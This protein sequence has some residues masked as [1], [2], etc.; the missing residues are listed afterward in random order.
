MKIIKVKTKS[1]KFR[2][3]KHAQW[4][5]VHMEHFGHEQDPKLWK[6]IDIYYKAVEGTKIVGVL[7]GDAMAGVFHLKELIVDSTIRGQGIGKRMLEQLEAELSSI[8]VHTIYLET[9]KEWKSVEFYKKLGFFIVG[10]LPNFY[11]HFDFVLMQK[12]L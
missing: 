11:E 12:Q 9:G 4:E 7:Q 1:Q 2:V 8:N 5:K 3:F 6:V 10:E